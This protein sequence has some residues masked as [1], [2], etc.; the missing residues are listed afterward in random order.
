MIEDEDTG[1]AAKCVICGSEEYWE[2]GHL[3]A[4][5]DLSFNQCNGGS[6]C[7]RAE[8]F[9]ELIESAFIEFIKK[10]IEPNFGK[11]NDAQQWCEL[12]KH[13]KKD[14][15]DVEDYIYIDGDISAQIFIEMLENCGA[16]SLG[17][18]LLED[19]GPGMTSVVKL[20][21]EDEPESAVNLALAELTDILSHEILPHTLS[22]AAST[23]YQSQSGRLDAK[24]IKVR[25]F[26]LELYDL[27]NWLKTIADTNNTFHAPGVWTSL[28]VE[29][30]KVC[31]E[32]LGDVSSGNITPELIANRL[33]KLSKSHCFTF[34]A[35]SGS[36]KIVKEK[37]EIFSNIDANGTLN[38]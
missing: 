21:F 1:E 36:L 25:D 12:W 38:K 32:A 24:Q 33:E 11:S 5:F 2:C 13:A 4:E 30:A 10:G 22:V 37:L 31:N 16:S 9:A 20:L 17:G 3:V 28:F 26:E 14:F 29:Q 23:G 34:S 18:M 8:E 27:R 19:G 6:F 15:D 35:L 7:N